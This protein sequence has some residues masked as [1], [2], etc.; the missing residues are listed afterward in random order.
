MLTELQRDQ[1]RQALR[2]MQIIVATL[3]FGVVSFF[4]VTLFI[5]SHGGGNGPD[6]NHIVTYVGMGFAIVGAIVWIILRDLI[7][8]QSRKSVLA[9]D[10]RRLATVYQT[11][12]IISCAL[13]EGI[14]F[15]NLV[16]YLIEHQRMSLVI[17]GAY[18]VILLNQFPTLNRLE[19][20]VERELAEVDQLRQLEPPR[21]R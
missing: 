20:W 2:P 1:L 19:N 13:L 4:V 8:R 16:A 12:L 5:G 15:L 21:G 7:A 14:A 3:A 10:T 9:G 17:A 18:L 11:R 6:S